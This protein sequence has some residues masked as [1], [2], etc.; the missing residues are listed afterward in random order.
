MWLTQDIRSH[1]RGDIYGLKG[2]AVTLISEH[3]DVLIVEH[4][5]GHRFPVPKHLV[6]NSFVRKAPPQAPVKRR[7]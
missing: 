2:D 3:E 6:S 5:K 4:S 7:R 1:L